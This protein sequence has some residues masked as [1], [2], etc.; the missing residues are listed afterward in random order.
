MREE[1]YVVRHRSGARWRAVFLT[2]YLLLS[3]PSPSLP[4][5]GGVHNPGLVERQSTRRRSAFCYDAGGAVAHFPGLLMLLNLFPLNPPSLHTCV[6]PPPNRRISTVVTS[7]FRALGS[8]FSRAV[9][10]ALGPT[11]SCGGNGIG[12]HRRS[13]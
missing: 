12:R 6:I 8:D 1:I 11:P 9:C 13:P 2:L 4:M 10:A 3:S 7:G 5:G